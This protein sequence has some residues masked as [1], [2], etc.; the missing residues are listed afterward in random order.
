MR[1]RHNNPDFGIHVIATGSIPS[2]VTTRPIIPGFVDDDVTGQFLGCCLTFWQS[3]VFYQ[4]VIRREG[5]YFDILTVQTY[6]VM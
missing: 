6:T 5:P 4:A 1:V 3:V 2:L